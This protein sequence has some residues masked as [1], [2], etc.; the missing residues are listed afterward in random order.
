MD[1][2]PIALFLLRD[3]FAVCRLDADAPLPEWTQASPLLS[4]VRSARELSIVCSVE[5]V[6]DGVRAETG[7]RCFEVAGP[8]DFDAT[9]ILARITGA[10]A[11]TEIPVLAVSSFDTDYIL[12]REARARAARDALEGAGCTITDL[13]P[14]Q[15]SGT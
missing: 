14:E 9:G 2:P 6:P 12:V 15:G 10:L 7:F 11:A 8:L 5:C 3:T 13:A 1:T 4:V